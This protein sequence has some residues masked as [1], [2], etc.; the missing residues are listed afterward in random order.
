MLHSFQR[1]LAR[2]ALS[3]L[4]AAALGGCATQRHAETTLYQDLGGKEGIAAIVEAMLIN[5]AEDERVAATFAAANLVRLRRLLE[6]QFCNVTD[7]PCEYT[8][9]SMRESHRGM[10]VTETEF[11]ATVEALVDAMDELRVAQTTQ[12]RLLA[13]LAPLQ[14]EIVYQ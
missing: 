8:G 11:N 10:V 14:A 6:E 7:G 1:S 9:F 4:A 13:R 2:F 12:N 5:T 3:A